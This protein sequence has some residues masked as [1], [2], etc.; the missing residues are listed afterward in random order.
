MRGGHRQ[1]TK[2]HL[3]GDLLGGASLAF[4]ANVET[5]T[6]L[7]PVAVS[8]IKPGDLGQLLAQSNAT[9][10]WMMLSAQAERAALMDRLAAIGRGDAAGRVA[11]TLLDFRERLANFQP[12]SD[13]LEMPVTQEELGDYLGLTSVHINRTLRTLTAEALIE[14]EGLAIRLKDIDALRRRSAVPLRRHNG[15]ARLA[16][17]GQRLSGVTCVKLDFGCPRGA[18]APCLVFLPRR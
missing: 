5:L 3:P 4:D 17:A 6:A 14:R 2:F 10:T 12:I 18:I 11:A 16:A 1:I 9:V 8:R 7:T 13:M 15:T